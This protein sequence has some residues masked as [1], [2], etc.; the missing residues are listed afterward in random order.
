MKLEGVDV[1]Q[2]KIATWV[3]VV[4]LVI[5]AFALGYLAGVGNEQ[6]E[7][8]ITAVHSENQ[9]AIEPEKETAAEAVFPIDLNSADQHMLEC[10]PG[11][12]PE[13]AERIV[14][15]RNTVG[16]FLATEQLMDVEGIGEKRFDALKDLITVEVDHENIGS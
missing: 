8:V 12:G 5:T 15:Y 6:P 4:L 3:Y 9:H 1:T 14:A 13:L 10:L 11:V 7:I 2:Q 16:P